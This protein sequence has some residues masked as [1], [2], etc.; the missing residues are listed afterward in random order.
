MR[1]KP[2]IIRHKPGIIEHIPVTSAFFRIISGTKSF[3]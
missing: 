2:G 3:Q 1:Y